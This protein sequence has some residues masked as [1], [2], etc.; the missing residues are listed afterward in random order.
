MER[1]SVKVVKLAL[2]MSTGKFYGNSKLFRKIVAFLY[3]FSDFERKK[4]GVST[5]SRHG[6]KCSIVSVHRNIL[7]TLFPNT[8][9]VSKL[10][11]DFEPRITKFWDLSDFFCRFVKFAFY[12]SGRIFWGSKFF[13]T[14]CF[15]SC[16]FLDFGWNI[17]G[18]TTLF[19]T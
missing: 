3:L 1:F 19:W 14:S 16:L 11:L 8:K 17:F 4:N 7:W 13:T 18:A 12:V 6:C 5:K 15:S 10:S 9:L 2:H